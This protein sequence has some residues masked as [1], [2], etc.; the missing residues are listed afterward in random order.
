MI[1]GAHGFGPLHGTPDGNDRECGRANRSPHGQGRKEVGVGGG[2][3]VSNPLPGPPPVTSEPV[4][5]GPLGDV[6]HAN[7]SLGQVAGEFVMILFGFVSRSVF[8]CNRPL[9]I[10]GARTAEVLGHLCDYYLAV[11]SGST[12]GGWE[13]ERSRQ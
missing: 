7:C 8:T 2:E 6:E 4:T 13:W 9:C 1:D 10:G 3:G 5:H 12:C 11:M